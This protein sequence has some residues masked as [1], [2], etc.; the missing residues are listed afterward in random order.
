M[1]QLE[2][3]NTA[4]FKHCINKPVMLINFIETHECEVVLDGEKVVL[5]W[6]V[7][8]TNGWS[9]VQASELEILEKGGDN[10]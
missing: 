7:Y 9:W 1:S 3:G 5:R 2:V 10:Q 8:S 6:N 4:V